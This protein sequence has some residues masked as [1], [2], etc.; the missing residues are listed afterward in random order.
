MTT[1]QIASKLHLGD[2]TLLSGRLLLSLLFV[3]EGLE[4]ASHFGIAAKA[5]AALGVSS[6]LL[7]ATITLQLGAGLLVGLGLLTRLG[8][9]SLGLFCLA[10]A[11]LFHTNFASQN[12]LLHFEKDLA[13]A[14]GMF[15][16]TTAG[17]GSISLDRALTG[18]V[19]RRQRD[20]KTVGALV[21]AGR[22]LSSSDIK[23]PF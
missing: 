21:A 17:A 8:A 12:E 9:V 2:W 3:H 13:I 23:L 11:A 5:M 10:T 16:L 15:A 18:L 7:I 19:R 22:P 20:R 1:T 6:P 4:L 14:G